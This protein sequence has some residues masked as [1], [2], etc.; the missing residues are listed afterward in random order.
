MSGNKNPKLP[1]EKDEK[2]KLR[3]AKV[4]I[5]DIH[6]KEVDELSKILCVPMNRARLIKGLASFQLVPSIGEKLAEKIVH[7]LEI[8]SL[9]E[10]RDENGAE[11]F[12]KLESNLGVWTDPCVEDQIRCVIYYANHPKSNKQWFD[13]TEER[14]LYRQRNGYP[15]SRPKKAWYE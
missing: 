1:F 13:F 8:N 4:K 12:D 6:N 15:E 9:H 2:A 11:L 14:K 3:K 7:N 10:I 5:S